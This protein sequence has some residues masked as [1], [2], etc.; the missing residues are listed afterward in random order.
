MASGLVLCLQPSL[1]LLLPFWVGVAGGV[2]M[3]LVGFFSCGDK[4][5]HLFIAFWL[6]LVWLVL[7]GP[8]V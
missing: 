3:L 6:L 2:P 8:F 7:F 5:W 4:R 1:L